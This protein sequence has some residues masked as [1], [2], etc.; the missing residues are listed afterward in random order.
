ML[1]KFYVTRGFT[2]REAKARFGLM[3]LI[4]VLKRKRTRAVAKGILVTFRKRFVANE[5]TA[6]VQR[7]TPVAYKR[8][9]LSDKERISS[10]TVPTHNASTRLCDGFDIVSDYKQSIVQRRQ[11]GPIFPL[12]CDADELARRRLRAA[13]FDAQGKVPT[14]SMQTGRVAWSGGKCTTN[15]KEA[16]MRFLERRGGSLS[17]EQRKAAIAIVSSYGPEVTSNGAPNVS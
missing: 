2:T 1:R 11:Y 15:R 10:D 4:R 8:R 17:L 14:P 12:K 6:H 7:A 9:C 16:T 3:G 13:R 5:H